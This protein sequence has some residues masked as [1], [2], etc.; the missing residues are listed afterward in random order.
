MAVL[1]SVLL[2]PPLLLTKWK[3]ERGRKQPTV[4]NDIS[5]G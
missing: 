2:W 3:K 5:R 4:Q 1:F